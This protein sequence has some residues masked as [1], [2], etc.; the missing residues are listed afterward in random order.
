MFTAVR[1]C[2]S[3]GIALVGASV[4]AVTPISPP[5]TASVVAS[6]AVQLA[7]I[8]SPLQLYTQVLETTLANVDAQF[9]YYFSE[10]FP[11]IGATLENYAQAF[12]DAVTALQSGR[13]DE[14]FVSVTRIVLQP[15]RSIVL[16]T[17]GLLGA[18][19][20]PSQLLKNLFGAAIGPLLNGIAG[21]GLAI[22]DV[23]EAITTFDVIGLVNSVI[24][25]PARIIDGVLNGV[26][27][28]S[29]GSF[30]NLPGLLTPRF[31]RPYS[32]SLI[33]LLIRLDQEMGRAITPI[34]PFPPSAIN[35]WS[36]P[37]VQTMMHTTE[38]A[39][40]PVA[41]QE[42]LPTADE[43]V[44]EENG[45][46]A[47]ELDLPMFDV[48]GEDVLGEDVPEEDIAEAVVP[49]EVGP[50]EVALG[51]DVSEEADDLVEEEPALAQ[52]QALTDTELTDD[53]PSSP[54]PTDE[55]NDPDSETND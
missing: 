44:P 15:L 3:A 10:P 12:E 41:V 53:E 35:T 39:T 28:T 22:A 48:P 50:E 27:G 7:A 42:Q 47:E 40:E 14:L 29:F 21:T 54:A 1:P 6:P 8:P 46:V 23:F 34:P 20:L 55:A 49:E 5:P 9:E 2:L 38:P 30:D 36:G 52:E 19:Y 32:S 4:I 13:S 16:S 18:Y 43:A 17:G 26:P 25:I 31:T 33:T 51:E 45:P 24:N 11:I 37:E